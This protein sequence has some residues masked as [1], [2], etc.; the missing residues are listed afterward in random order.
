MALGNILNP[1]PFDNQT[2]GNNSNNSN[3]NITSNGSNGSKPK[4]KTLKS[5]ERNSKIKRETIQQHIN[6]PLESNTNNDNININ[7]D[8]NNTNINTNDDN[9]NMN[10]DNINMNYDNSESNELA[11]FNPSFNDIQNSV[12]PM[13]NQWKSPELQFEDKSVSQSND[14]KITREGF[15]LLKSAYNDNYYK[16]DNSNPKNYINST[17]SNISNYELFKKLDNI[18][19]LLEEH[20]E[21]KSG[22]ITEELILYVFLGVFIIFI[23]DS[24]V[25]VGRYT[26]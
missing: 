2:K 4:N 17:P 7:N 22:Y 16:Q 12:I 11:D 21:E 18:L 15:D 20:H 14:N 8:N 19:H 1:A 10:Y 25:K 3:T 26:R 23:L 6:E 13:L 5:N 9:I 24:F